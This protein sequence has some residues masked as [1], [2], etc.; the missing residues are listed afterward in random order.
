VRSAAFSIEARAKLL[1]PVDTGFLRNSIITEVINDLNA[2][3]IVGAE[4]GL[5]VELG[6]R[7]MRAQPFFIPAVEEVVKQFG[8]ELK[9]VI[10]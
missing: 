10:E 7:K 2:R 3:V 1:A 6:T 4:Y 5:Y 8:G 9:E